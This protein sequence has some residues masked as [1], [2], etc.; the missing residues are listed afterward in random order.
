M[1]NTQWKSK[2][3]KP[4]K[5]EELK[6]SIAHVIDKMV[7]NNGE[8]KKWNW[9]QY[10]TSVVVARAEGTRTKDIIEANKSKRMSFNSAT[11]SMEM[12]CLV[13]CLVGFLFI[14]LERRRRRRSESESWTLYSLYEIF[15]V[16]WNMRCQWE[17][18][19]CDVVFMNIS[20]IILTRNQTK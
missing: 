19:L 16:K 2:I 9:P 14:F 6:I 17:E 4:F 1:L 11:D 18:L 7:H 13:A 8:R 5:I 10:L 20:P 3:W 15:I 12:D